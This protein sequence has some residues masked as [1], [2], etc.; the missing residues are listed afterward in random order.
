MRSA[1][2]P[3]EQFSN[4]IPSSIVRYCAKLLMAQIDWQRLFFCTIS[5]VLKEHFSLTSALLISNHDEDVK[6][7]WSANS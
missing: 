5:I 2:N 3:T 6:D 4:F 7:G 1:E